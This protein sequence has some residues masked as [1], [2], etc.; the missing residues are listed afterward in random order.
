MAP[1]FKIWCWELRK[2]TP[3][4][5]VDGKFVAVSQNPVS[6]SRVTVRALDEPAFPLSLGFVNSTRDPR[7][8]AKALFNES[9]RYFFRGG[10]LIEGKALLCGDGNVVEPAPP[11]VAGGFISVGMS[12]GEVFLEVDGHAVKTPSS[13]S[14]EGTH[15]MCVVVAPAPS[16]LQPCW[17]F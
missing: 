4:V 10:I 13:T 2:K 12:E 16:D 6:T 9:P 11:L 3:W 17:T 15:W 1:G 14:T 7:Q 5:K 8:I